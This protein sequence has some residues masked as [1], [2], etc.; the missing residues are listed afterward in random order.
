MQNTRNPLIFVVIE[1]PIYNN[2]VVGFL[3][4]RKYNNVMSFSKGEESLEHLKLNPDMF[5][6]S[7]SMEDINGMELMKKVK[8]ELPE[9]DFFFL[10][11]QNDVE[12][13][14]N[15]VKHGATDYIVKND[16]ALAKLARSIDYTV[17]TTKSSKVRKGFKIGVI[18]FFIILFIIIMIILS[19]AIIFPKDFSFS[20]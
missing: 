8:A 16:K 5:V 20:L 11:G 4:S 6:C 2:L 12:V 9:T 17:N 10:S 14:V 3:K 13:A 1:S 7:Y 19:L 18:G 15:I